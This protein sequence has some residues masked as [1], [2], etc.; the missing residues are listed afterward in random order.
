MNLRFLALD[1]Q[2]NLKDMVDLNY[3]YKLLEITKLLLN[4]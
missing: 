4:W 2:K 1:S 3:N